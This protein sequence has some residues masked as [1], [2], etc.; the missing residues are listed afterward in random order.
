[1][2][3]AG[4][5]E[6]MQ[7]QL[8]KPV[9]GTLMVDELPMDDKPTK[10]ASAKKRYK[11]RNHDKVFIDCKW[12]FLQMFQIFIEVKSIG[13]STLFEKLKDKEKVKNGYD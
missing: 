4:G 10:D 11:R 2:E 13:K 1:M 5:H 9:E 3:P 8:C 7:D 6:M 12:L